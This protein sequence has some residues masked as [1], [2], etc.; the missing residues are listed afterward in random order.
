MESTTTSSDLDYWE[1]RAQRFANLDDGLPAVCSYGMPAFY[2]RAIELTQR[3]ALLPYLQVKPGERVLDVGCG[4]G[5]WSLPLAEAGA[6]VT[7][8]DLSATMIAEAARR[9]EARGVDKRCLFLQQDVAA[10]ELD[11]CFDLILCVTVLQHV[12]D[13]HHCRGAISALAERLCSGGRMVLLEAAPRRISM[14]CNTDV[15]RARTEGEYL[16]WFHQA[17]L[18]LEGV[19]GVDPA[20]FKIWYLPYHR[21]L[22][23]LLARS[24]LGLVTL[25][26]LPLDLALGGIAGRTAWHKVF[27]LRAPG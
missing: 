2:N 17:G 16:D 8:I 15:F 1:R 21:S 5:R 18:T 26:S 9:A 24:A 11:S 3:K 23:P 13:D 19:R 22:P 7:G 25:C 10:P 20:P 14:R 27:S 12:L 4:V 6:V